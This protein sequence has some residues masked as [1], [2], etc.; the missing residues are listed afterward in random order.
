MSRSRFV[1]VGVLTAVLVAT[2]TSL[3]SAD[4]WR[5]APEYVL[6]FAPPAHRAAYRA[7]VSPSSMEAVIAELA[8]DANLVR[9]PGAWTPRAETPLDAFGRSAPYDRWKLARVY[10]SRQP[11]VARG[12][13]MEGGVVTESWT[14]ISPYPN[15]DFTALQ[16][17]TLRLT[18][19]VP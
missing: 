16:A 17:G 5:E 15:R 8:D 14:L 13:R 1:A 9:V 18:L 11:R 12:A 4:A 2:G 19:R 6:L 10:G 7:F 3:R